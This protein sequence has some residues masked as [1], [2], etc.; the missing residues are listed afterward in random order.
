M[1]DEHQN[2]LPDM[3]DLR[4]KLSHPED[5]HS[6]CHLKA[7]LYI[8]KAEIT[9]EKAS[10]KIVVSLKKATLRLIL[11]GFE[12]TSGTRYNN[13]VKDGP[14]LVRI[15]SSVERTNSQGFSLEGGLELNSN[16]GIST[17]VVGD[18]D[19]AN[20]TV[21]KNKVTIKDSEEFYC[22]RA[23]GNNSWEIM[24]HD[25]SALDA[26]FLEDTVLC[27][28]TKLD[29][30]NQNYVDAYLSAHLHDISYKHISTGVVDGVVNKII[31][32]KE[33]IINILISKCLPDSDR[34]GWINFSHGVC[35]HE[36]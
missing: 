5:N 23:K 15:D 27:G 8:N 32:N 17:S 26:T 25:F 22:V 10:I 21:K 11:S 16:S 2:A 7:T 3:V 29:R 19:L 12:A 18:V 34:T 33:R 14:V 1:S 35:Y 9:C 36:C 28:L 6:D 31:T 4:T 13:A 24:N 30:F 20:K